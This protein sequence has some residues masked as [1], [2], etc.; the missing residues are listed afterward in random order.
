MH[1]DKKMQKNYLNIKKKITKK[2]QH[3]IHDSSKD[4]SKNV[5]Y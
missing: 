3:G 4:R 5:D 1:P 2:E